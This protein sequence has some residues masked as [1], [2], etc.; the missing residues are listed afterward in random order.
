MNTIKEKIDN[1][2]KEQGYK[3]TRFKGLQKRRSFLD[4][5]FNYTDRYASYMKEDDISRHVLIGCY[6]KPS[7]KALEYI[8]NS[9][10]KFNRETIID[11]YFDG[12]NITLRNSGWTC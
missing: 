1:L 7:V 2:A 12:G 6:K 9:V 4:K 5:A 10:S 3:L 11:I 8:R